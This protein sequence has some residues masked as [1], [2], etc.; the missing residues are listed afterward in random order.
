[1]SLTKVTY[2][3]ISGAV[4]NILD[5]GA[6]G[7][8]V[9]DDTAAIQ[10]AIDSVNHLGTVFFPAGTY[11]ITDTLD[12]IYNDVWQS[13]NL[14]GVGNGSKIDWRGGNG[15]PMI[16]TRGPGTNGSGFYAKP[17]IEKLYL[18]GNAFTGDPYTNVTGV[19]VG[20]TPQNV[21]SGVCNVTIR[22]CLISHVTIGIAVYY[23]SDEC[24]IEG[25]YVEHFTGYGIY[26]LEGGSGVWINRNH[27]S[28]GS[29]TS[30]G[31]YTSRS[32]GAIEQNI[33]QGQEISVA[34]LVAGL[35]SFRGKAISIRNNYLESQ[36]GGD[37]GIALYGTDTAVIENNTINGFAGA[38]L[39]LLSD[40]DDGIPCKNISIGVN[41][42]TQSAGAITALANASVNSIDCRITGYQQTDG[43]V[44]TITGP[45][46]Q[47]QNLNDYQTGSFTAELY[48]GATQQTITSNCS[49]TKI[50]RVVYITGTIAM[51]A[52]VSGSGN[53]TIQGLP[54]TVSSLGAYGGSMGLSFANL[55][56]TGQVSATTIPSTDSIQL[57][58]TVSAGAR[59]ALTHANF[60]SNSELTF[61]GFYFV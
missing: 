14:L 61:T 17:Y 56:S 13:V 16:H 48:F 41:R 26:N 7:D 23:E 21:F 60:A 47:T 24:S 39:I 42:H 58:Q 28:D 6:V 36:L 5:F 29:V 9:T 20:D 57:W 59:S 37:Y 54:I 43:A 3:M 19:Q 12:I 27:I 51:A 52:A 4:A 32:S 44:T 49:Y 1:M 22:D 34:I 46:Q 8:G 11:K 2:S 15:K 55:P 31:I 35:T 40:D 53:A 50:G 33:I 38:T 25:N 18:Y 10:A 30:V 45:F